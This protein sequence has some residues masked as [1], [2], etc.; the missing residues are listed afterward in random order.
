MRFVRFGQPGSER[1]GVQ[2]DDETILDISAIVD[3]IGHDTVGYLPAVIERIGEGVGLPR[4]HAAGIRLGAPIARPHKIIGVG[5]NYAAHAAESGAELPTEPVVFMKAT[6]SLSGPYDDIV[7]P[8]GFYKV[9]WEVEL[10]LVIGA[11]AS[12]LSDELAANDCIAGYAIGHDVSERAFQLERGGQWMKGKSA[13]T[14]SPLGPWLVTPDEVPDS[15]NLELECRVNGEL[16]QAA[17]TSTMIFSPDHIVWYI[18]QFMTIE[19][20]DVILTGTPEGIALASGDYLRPGDQVRLEI[21]GLG[22]QQQICVG[23]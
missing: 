7:F 18:S 13:D 1:P 5:L 12:C 23:A 9:D 3:D 22:V 20:G 16:R 19:P 4:V 6:S 2:W 10:A 21:T 14:F 17:S 15:L 8:P 11:R